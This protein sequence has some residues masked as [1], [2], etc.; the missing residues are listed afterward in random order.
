MSLTQSRPNHLIELIGVK[1]LE[2]ERYDAKDFDDLI[3]QSK[4]DCFMFFK[5]NCWCLALHCCSHLDNC[6]ILSTLCLA[7]QFQW[8]PLLFSIP[9]PCITCH[10]ELNDIRGARLNR[11]TT[12]S[13]LYFCLCR[14]LFQS[15]NFFCCSLQVYK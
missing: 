5:F 15:F 2:C 4:F 14:F 12:S 3:E 10:L 9:R 13:C 7:W 1:L 11:G 6:N 8:Y